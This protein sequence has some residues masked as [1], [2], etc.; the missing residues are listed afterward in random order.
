[1]P[2]VTTFQQQMLVK[3]SFYFLGARIDDEDVDTD[4]FHDIDTGRRVP[5]GSI[6]PKSILKNGGFESPTSPPE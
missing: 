2:F 3:L 5:L 4:S 6:P 1:M